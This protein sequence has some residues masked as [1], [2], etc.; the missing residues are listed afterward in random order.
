[1]RV[2]AAAFVAASI[3]LAGVLV[4]AETRGERQVDAP[5]A[6]ELVDRERASDASPGQGSGG[7][8]PREVK[9]GEAG[10]DDHDGEYE[11]EYE[12]SDD[13]DDDDSDDENSG[14]GSD[15]SGSESDDS[16]SG[17]DD[18]GSDNSGSGSDDSGG[19]D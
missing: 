3:F 8:V 9:R 10:D 15:D 12:G 14:S 1:V 4:G 7:S 11:Y 18:S 5:V 19:H 6:I 17:S 13:Y 2:A 16:G